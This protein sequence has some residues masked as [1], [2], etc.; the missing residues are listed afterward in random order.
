[1]RLLIQACV[2]LFALFAAAASATDAVNVAL[3]APA[4]DHQLS[5]ADRTLVLP[6]GNWTAIAR[7][8]GHLNVIGSGSQRRSSHYTVYA[9]D[10]QQGR[11][12]YGVVMRMPAASTPVARWTDDPCKPAELLLREDF[13]G[14][15][16]QPQCL[17]VRKMR[18]H[19]TSDAD[20][21]YAQAKQWAAANGVN[22]TG[23]FYEVYYARFAT[24]DFGLMRAFIPA[25]AVGGDEEVI[26]WARQLPPVLRP[27]FERRVTQATLPPWPRK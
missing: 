24:N 5:W 15:L 12:Q 2:G 18:S 6:P 1:M 8:E 26:A 13:G 17:T 9:I 3:P 25:S 23:A 14:D 20:P 27:L 16:R 21:F 7:S 4:A 22:T 11:M 19:L 10:T